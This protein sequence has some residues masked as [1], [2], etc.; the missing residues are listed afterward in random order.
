M[1]ISDWSSDVCSS[2]LERR[3]R[4]AEARLQGNTVLWDLL[5]RAARGTEV[6]GASYS[7]Y[8]TLYEQV[9][10]HKPVEILELGTG[11]STVAMAQALR[12]N[13]AEGHPRGRVTSMEED[14]YWHGVALENLPEDVRAYEIGRA[15]V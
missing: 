14:A 5:S 13:E 15:H 9:R 1:R 3:S 8:W 7:D 10:L 6:T 4:R 12:E 2:D 11:I